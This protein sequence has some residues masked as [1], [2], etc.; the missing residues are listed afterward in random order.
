M[1]HSEESGEELHDESDYEA[2]PELDRY[3]KEMLDDRP[4]APS[5]RRE[6][7]ARQRAEEV[8]SARDA[9]ERPCRPF[10]RC[11][12]VALEERALRGCGS[13]DAGSTRGPR[14]LEQVKANRAS[15][16]ELERLGAALKCPEA[17]VAKAE[18]YLRK[19]YTGARCLSNGPQLAS[20]PAACLEIA[21]RVCK[22][23]I[24]R[25]VLM[26]KAGVA[27]KD[28]ANYTRAVAHCHCLLGE[29]GKRR[30]KIAPPGPGRNRRQRNPPLHV[31]SARHLMLI[32]CMLSLQEFGARFQWQSFAQSS[33]ATASRRRSAKLSR[34]SSASSGRRFRKIGARMRISLGCH[35]SAL[36]LVLTRHVSACAKRL[37]K[38]R[39][40]V[41]ARRVLRLTARCWMLI[42]PQTRFCHRRSLHHGR[43]EQ[44]HRQASREERAAESW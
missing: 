17:V 41:L 39:P 10:A 13:G 25:D 14:A 4:R 27:E 2:I 20:L 30:R 24:S 36:S 43:E 21:A 22:K 29:W 12:A 40:T 31:A 5:S 37:R 1:V 19:A 15:N 26:R 33:S 34:L 18:G 6:L 28:V 3:E 8:M 32:C 44:A 16:L 23:P 7:T 38:W 42:G 11:G 35:L 9:K